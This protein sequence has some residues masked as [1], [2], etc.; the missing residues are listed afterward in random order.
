MVNKEYFSMAETNKRKLQAKLESLQVYGDTLVGW[1]ENTPP[2]ETVDADGNVNPSHRGFGVSDPNSPNHRV[3]NDPGSK[4]CARSCDNTT[5][6]AASKSV[7]R[8]R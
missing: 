1:D 5:V 6:F 4:R 8:T 2:N 3:Y 7:N